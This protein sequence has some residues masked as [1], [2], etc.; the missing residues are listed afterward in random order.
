MTHAVL[1]RQGRVALL[2]RLGE[3]SRNNPC[4]HRQSMPPP[5]RTKRNKNA[6]PSLVGVRVTGPPHRLNRGESRFPFQP[7]RSQDIECHLQSRPY[8]RPL[9]RGQYRRS[10][11][12]DREWS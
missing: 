11:R 2:S 8:A 4:C 3:L 10:R 7:G 5:G 12:G 1:D 6:D 9:L